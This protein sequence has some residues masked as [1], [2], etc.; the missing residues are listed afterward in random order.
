MA[1]VRVVTDSACDLTE[2]LA[3]TNRVSV[4]P[5][6]IRF[7]AE[8]FADRTELSPTEFWRRCRESATLPETAAPSP[9]SFQTAF[10]AAA[11][12]GADAIVCITISSKVSATYQSA[13]TGASAMEGRLPVH[14]VDSESLTMGQGLMCI[15]AAEM[16]AD[17]ASAADIVAHVEGLIPRTRVYGA[18]GA[19]DH[20]Q[21]G[22]RIGGA[23][24]LLGSILA[25]KPVLVVEDG[26]VAEESRQRTR[27]RAIDYLVQKAVD[28]APLERLALCNGAADDIEAVT[29]KLAEVK[30]GHPLVVVDLGPVVGTHAGPGTIGVCFIRGAG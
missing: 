30:T 27:S 5:L 3:A 18:L 21:R 23:K 9:G 13:L 12:E 22:G 19:L 7:G 10:A 11:D 6:T 29:A 20:L 8:E 26:E 4:V 15:D 2:E 17:G 14:V 16:A 25:I 1:G 28:Q 24:A